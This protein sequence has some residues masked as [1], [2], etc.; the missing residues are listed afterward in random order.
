MTKPKTKKTSPKK[1]K[2][3]AKERIFCNEYIKTLNATQS[4]LKA[5]PNASYN[6]AKTEGCKLLTK[7]Y[8]QEYI[9]DRLEAKEQDSIADANEVLEYFTRVL[10]G[11]EKDTLGFDASIKD[12]NK[13]GE[14]LA[15]R[16]ALFED[17]AKDE[18]RPM[19]K[20]EIEV[21]DNRD[22]EAVLY[23]NRQNEE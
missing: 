11:Q 17:K 1:E 15:K 18:A 6:T 19:P 14:L 4:Y 7:P 8:I 22:L 10:R 13:A 5:Y 20:I 12:R 23:E 3:N 16:Y 21:V 2:P 9:Q